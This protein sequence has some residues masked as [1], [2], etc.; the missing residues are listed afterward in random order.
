MGKA[1]CVSARTGLKVSRKQ[2]YEQAGRRAETLSA[3]VLRLK[4]YRIMERRYKTSVGEI[5]LIARRRNTL[6]I[7]E[8]KQ[9]ETLLAARESLT[10]RNRQRV[11]KAAELYVARTPHAQAL[12]IRFDGVF[13]VGRGVWRW[14]IHHEIDLWR[15]Y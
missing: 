13:I 10:Y 7:I 4:G 8:V 12:A 11:M 14:R 2:R 15:V 9:R 6:A 1:G 5:D 3:W